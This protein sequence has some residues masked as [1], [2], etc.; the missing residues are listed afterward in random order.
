MTTRFKSAF[1]ASAII[2]LLV[3]S[4][5][6]PHAAALS[7]VSQLSANTW[8]AEAASH[9][10]SSSGE[11]ASGSETSYQEKRE[12]VL[13]VRPCRAEGEFVVFRW[14]FRRTVV[15]SAKCGGNEVAI[16]QVEQQ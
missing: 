5:N 15:G 1:I 11:I 7:P 16:V 9:R 4:L 13:N 8:L 6:N 2:A 10:N 14:P 3:P 12:I